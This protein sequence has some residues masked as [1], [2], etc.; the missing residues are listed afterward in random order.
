MH[1]NHNRKRCKKTKSVMPKETDERY[2]GGSVPSDKTEWLRFWEHQ[3]NACGKSGEYVRGEEA[4]EIWGQYASGG[5]IQVSEELSEWPRLAG[6][7]M[8]KKFSVGI[9]A[10]RGDQ[11]N[12]HFSPGITIVAESPGGGSMAA[13]II[14]GI[15]SKRG[16]G[17]ILARQEKNDRWAVVKLIYCPTWYALFGDK[18]FGINWTTRSKMRDGDASFKLAW[19]KHVSQL[20]EFVR[21]ELPNGI[22]DSVFIDFYA[23]NDTLHELPQDRINLLLSSDAEKLTEVLVRE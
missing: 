18:T 11:P 10:V 15:L 12:S 23:S 1:L 4:I 2:H 21:K 9:I 7:I 19:C 5:G 22:I 6:Q 14:I 3:R 8:G 20:V 16:V 17:G 13:R